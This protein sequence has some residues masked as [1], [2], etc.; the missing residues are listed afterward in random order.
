ML[1][2]TAIYFPA[3][4]ASGT[5]HTYTTLPPHDPSK[6]RGADRQLSAQ[7]DALYAEHEAKQAEADAI[8]ERIAQ[9][10]IALDELSRP[11]RVGGAVQ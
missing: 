4:D 3:E 11:M 10:E 8:L 2:R 5:V 1:D 7:I 9:L 6:V